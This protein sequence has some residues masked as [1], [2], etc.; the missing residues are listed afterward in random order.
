MATFGQTSLVAVPAN[1]AGGFVLGPIMFFGMLSV[2]VGFV[3]A[4]LSVP[5]NVVAGLFTG[6][7]L[8]VAAWFPPF[9]RRLQLAGAHAWGF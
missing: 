9:V 3:W 5:L 6:F 4:G 1:I 2:F 8:T 7:L